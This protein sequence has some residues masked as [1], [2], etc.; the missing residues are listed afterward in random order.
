MATMKGKAVPTVAI[1]QHYVDEASA[2]ERKR[3]VEEAL[4]MHARV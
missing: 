3:T 1:L 2:P 4:A